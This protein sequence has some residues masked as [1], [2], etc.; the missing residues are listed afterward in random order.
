MKIVFTGGG[1][2]GHVMPNVALIEQLQ[3]EIFYIGT[4]GMEKQLVAPLVKSG[5]VTEFLQ[6]DACKL[7]RKFALSNLLV[8][9]R[10]AK[11]IAQ[12]KKHLARV[13]PD[14][15]FSKGGFVGLPVV[16][17]SKML[18][19]PAIVHES[20]LSMGLA[21]K[22][23]SKFATTLSAF[24][25]KNATRVGAIVRNSIKNGNKKQGLETMGF[26]GSKPVLTVV[27]GSLGAQSLV[28]AICQ[29]SCLAEQFDIFVVTGNKT[30]DCNF[31]HQAQFVH[32]FG[33]VLSATDVCLTRAGANA[34][35][36]LT[37]AN[38]PF[39]A[40]PLTK[41]SRGEQVQNA[42]WF[43]QQGCGIVLNDSNLQ[44]NLQGAVLCCHN[45]RHAFVAKQKQL[46]I[47][48]TSKVLNYI[49]Q[50]KVG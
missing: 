26:D 5:K 13:Q 10:L 14:I 38:V 49:L 39:V 35:A 43:E 11:S 27:G 34:L 12:A 31:A 28:D 32:N 23:S 25:I 1:T 42:R 15:V 50:H 18:G 36:E 40:V 48:G 6:I 21:N 37:I 44:Q 41:Q 16:V 2:A 20:D 24:P 46:N 8:P 47:D 7:K 19:I 3:E 29:N 4:N 30:V 45:N 9:F 22:I 17:A 33:D